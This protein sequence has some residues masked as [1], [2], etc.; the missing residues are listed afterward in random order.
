MGRRPPVSKDCAAIVPRHPARSVG[1]ED[2]GSSR[3]LGSGNGNAYE[4]RAGR[5][6]NSWDTAREVLEAWR[7]FS[8]RVT[9]E[10]L[11]P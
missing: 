4:V 11:D 9:E 5:E 3:S 2:R 7:D 10:A 1:R 6:A 8:A